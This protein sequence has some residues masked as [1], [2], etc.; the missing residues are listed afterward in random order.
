[1][2][3]FLHKNPELYAPER[4][5]TLIE[6]MVSM[7]IG[8]FLILGA[9]TVYM[10]SKT[11]YRTADNLSRVQ[12]DVRFAMDTIEPDIRLVR[13]WGRNNNAT[14]ILN[15][16]GVAVF[17]GGADIS[18]WALNLTQSIQV[19]DNV[20][21]LAAIPC[22]PNTV[23]RPNSD[24]LITRHASSRT[25]PLNAGQIQLQA[26]LSEGQLFNNGV[27]PAG[28]G[29]T[30]QTHDLV[31]NIYYVDNSSNNPN[32][33]ARFATPSLR[34]KTLVNGVM[35][36]Q[37]VIPGV[38]NMQIQLG[39]DTDG[40][41]SVDRY[42]DPSNPIVAASTIMAVRIW[43]LVRAQTEEFD[44]TDVG[45]YT[46]LDAALPQIVPGGAPGPATLFPAGFRRLQVTKTIFLRN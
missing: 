13:F 5:M 8:M 24:I 38:E 36:D 2:N 35:N 17:C 30:S 42:V 18:N 40:S 29:P 20:Y 21:N 12:E 7:V 26:D 28:F 44:Y 22:A 43:M 45:P 10:Q 32:P 33:A 34:R 9:V 41:G 11:N 1:M 25:M 37:E 14:R 31:V 19:V 39:L 27:V 15:P 23:A 3:T 4:G 16:A 6:L 46:P